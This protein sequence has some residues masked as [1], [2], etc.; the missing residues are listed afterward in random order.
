MGLGEGTPGKGWG[1]RG[2]RVRDDDTEETEGWEELR[3][4]GV[5]RHGEW[6]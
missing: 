6:E 2:W 4:D 3:V 5:S 1:Q